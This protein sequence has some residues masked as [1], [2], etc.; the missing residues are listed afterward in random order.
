MGADNQQLAKQ[1]FDSLQAGEFSDELLT[2]DFHSWTL[3]SGASDKAKFLGG[4]KLFAAV[5]KGG[6][7]YTI[8]TLTSEKNRIVAETSSS[9]QLINGESVD[10]RAV[11]IMEIADGKIASVKE[12]MNPA[13]PREKL[14]P[15]IQKML[16]E[17]N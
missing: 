3:S 11:F 16:S 14:G 4:I 10:T 2:E 5:I 15:P 9:W 13:V 1:F 6:P 7:T 17:Q 8:E 12:Y